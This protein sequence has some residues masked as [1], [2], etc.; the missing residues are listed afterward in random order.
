MRWTRPTYGWDTRF[1]CDL[2]E[3]AQYLPVVVELKTVMKDGWRASIEREVKSR[4]KEGRRDL[5]LML[6][7]FDEVSVVFEVQMVLKERENLF[8]ATREYGKVILTS[9]TQFFR[10]GE[11]EKETLVQRWKKFS[12]SKAPGQWCIHGSREYMSLCSMMGRY[13][14]ILISRWA[15]RSRRNSGMK[16]RRRFSMSRTSP[17]ARF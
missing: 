9:R 8:E 2:A 16:R 7:G 13:E 11:E 1:A 10:S 6:D 14:S 3:A 12:A 15:K 4:K 5:L 17:A